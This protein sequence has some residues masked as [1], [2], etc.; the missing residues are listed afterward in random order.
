MLT[1]IISAGFQITAT[2]PMRTER[3]ARPR[4]HGANALASSVVL[5]CRSRP[6]TA[7]NISLGGFLTA[8]RTEMPAALN[9]LT[10]EAHIAPVDLAQAAIGPGMEVYS[11]YKGVK[12]T[13]DG[14]LVNVSVREALIKIN[15][16]IDRYH[17]E[18]EG[19]FDSHTRFCLAWFKQYDFTHGDYDRA[20]VLARANN[21]AI[22]TM[23]GRVLTAESGRVWLLSLDAYDDTHPNAQ[24]SLLQITTWEACHLMIYHLNPRNEDGR[25]I[26]GAVEVGTAMQNNPTSDPVASVERL[27]RILYSHYDRQGNAE[28][29]FLFNTLV[30]SWN[31]IEE[32]IRNPQQGHLEFDTDE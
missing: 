5:V 13:R 7:Q 26:E 9:R 25:G 12:T 29:A 24:L 11:R 28:N 32:N 27:A 30:T 1:A 21:I 18:Q 22:D 15:E 4:A 10:R 20:V 31:A 14:E 16:E 6:D 19:E 23:R 2:W 17:A 3:S 8:L